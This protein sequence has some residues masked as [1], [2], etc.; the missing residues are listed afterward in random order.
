MNEWSYTYIHL[1]AFM[2]CVGT[3]GITWLIT[4]E[5][6]GAKS[7]TFLGNSRSSHVKKRGRDLFEPALYMHTPFPP[8]LNPIFI[9]PHLHLASDRDK[10]TFRHTNWHS[11]VL[12]PHKLGRFFLF[13]LRS[14]L[15]SIYVIVWKIRINRAINNSPLYMAVAHTSVIPGGRVCLGELDSSLNF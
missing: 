12:T 11:T 6:G 10:F 3:I 9:C 8:T 1:Y 13:F 14:L 4:R 15:I 7:N 5:G 2:V